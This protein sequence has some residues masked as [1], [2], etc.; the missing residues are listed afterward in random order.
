VQ[1]DQLDVAKP[2]GLSDK[3]F[4]ERNG[5]RHAAV[6][7]DALT[8]IDVID[9]FFGGAELR[10]LV[11][12]SRVV[13]G[14]RIG[15]RLG[16]GLE[17]RSGRGSTS[18]EVD[19]KDR[20]GRDGLDRPR[21]EVGVSGRRVGGVARVVCFFLRHFGALTAADAAAGAGRGEEH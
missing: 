3:R 11:G 19:L 1:V 20:R 12:S 10:H 15:L 21:I 5:S 6:N 2:V 8:R 18:L 16:L 9:R 7:E 4:H 14:F 13:L 17:W